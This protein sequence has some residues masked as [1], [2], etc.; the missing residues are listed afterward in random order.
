MYFW[1]KIHFAKVSIYFMGAE[2]SL[3]SHVIEAVN[4]IWLRLIYV[5]K[6]FN[7]TIDRRRE[8]QIL[9]KSQAISEFSGML[10]ENRMLD[11]CSS[12]VV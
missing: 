1:S 5:S 6:Q 10:R 2:A 8:Y 11:V 7:R 9:S 3:N 12:I 4:V